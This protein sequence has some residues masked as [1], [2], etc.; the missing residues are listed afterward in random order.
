MLQ[1]KQRDNRSVRVNH[2]LKRK[3]KFSD[4]THVKIEAISNAKMSKIIKATACHFAVQETNRMNN[5]FSK[6]LTVINITKSF[7]C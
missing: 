6:C 2:S 4:C 7:I 3:P 5:F 1:H